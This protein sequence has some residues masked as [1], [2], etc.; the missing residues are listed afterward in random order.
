MKGKPKIPLIRFAK[1]VAH[2]T[3][4]PSIFALKKSPICGKCKSALSLHQGVNELTG[5][6]LE[7][8][9]AQKSASRGY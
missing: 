1:N 2:S 7:T 8:I 5:L 3:V 9:F 4:W 6:S